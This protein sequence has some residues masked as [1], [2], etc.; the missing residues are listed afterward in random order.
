MS[1]FDLNV[2]ANIAYFVLLLSFLM[3][4]ILAAYVFASSHV[5]HHAVLPGGL[6]RNRAGLAQGIDLRGDGG[7]IVAPPSIHPSGRL[8][9]WVPGRMPDEITLAP[10]PRWLII[11]IRGPSQA[12]PSNQ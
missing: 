5:Y 3:R 11:P 6:T 8:Y 9:E 10:L 1:D 2:I 7:Y 4:D 12:I